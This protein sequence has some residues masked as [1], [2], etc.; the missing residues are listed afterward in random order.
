[1]TVMD[2]SGTRPPEARRRAPVRLLR[3][4]A[5]AV[6]GSALILA[7]V[8]MLVP[9]GPGVAAILA[10]LGLLCTEFPKARRMSHR[11]NGY[12]QAA[13]RTARTKPGRGRGD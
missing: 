10:G 1:M 7:G 12:V 9:P 4:A 6:A 11:V 8:A 3:K 5:V 2:R 13:W